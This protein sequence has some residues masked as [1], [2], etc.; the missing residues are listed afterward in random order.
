MGAA[1]YIV[2]I[3]FIMN[4]VSSFLPEKTIFIP[5][6]MLGLFVLSAAIMGFL[7]LSEPFRLYMDNHKQE[8]V[9]FFLKIVGIF[10]CFLVLL[11]IF[12]FLK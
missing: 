4:A 2:F 3:V 10:A 12:L 8:A 1:L 7:F 11:L 6:A 9:S 5:M